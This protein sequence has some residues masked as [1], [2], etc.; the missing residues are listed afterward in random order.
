M[1]TIP[2]PL[3]LLLPALLLLVSAP[4]QTAPRMGTWQFTT[5]QRAEMA[6]VATDGDYMYFKLGD[7]PQRFRITQLA[8]GSRDAALKWAPLELIRREEIRLK[9]PVKPGTDRERAL[10]AAKRNWK[11][12][13]ST[14]S[15]NPS[16]K[17]AQPYRNMVLAAGD[18]Y[19]KQLQVGFKIRR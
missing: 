3:L 5:G 16:G 2:R 15:D 8:K 18:D 19:A 7:V 12:I 13:H 10:K 9:G 11:Q 4:A 14:F 17:L 1:N 6:I